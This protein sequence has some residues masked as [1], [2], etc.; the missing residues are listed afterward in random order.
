MSLS[1]VWWDRCCGPGFT[2]NEVCFWGLIW[3][4]RYFRFDL[5]GHEAGARARALE[6]ERSS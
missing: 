2:V 3:L 1:S 5:K 4:H 6:R